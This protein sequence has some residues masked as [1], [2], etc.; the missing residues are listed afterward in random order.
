MSAFWY[1]LVPV[2]GAFISRHN[3]RIFRQRFND[4]CLKPMLDYAAYVL[5]PEEG[6][7]YRFIGGFESTDNRTL[8]IRSEA[9]T[10]P[11]ILEGAQTY[12]LPMAE[13]EERT[14]TLDPRG[15]APEK[16]RWDRVSSLT[17]GA[18][19]FVG[20]K[21]VRQ[22]DR[23]VFAA[24]KDCPLL[25]IFYDGN[26]RSLPIRTIRAG[27]NKNEYWNTI[28]PY[29]FIAGAFSYLI[30]AMYFLSR[31]VFRLTAVTACIALFTPL[32]PILP[33][34][35]VCTLWYQ[36]LWR[37]ARIFR[38][39]R[40]ILHFPLKYKGQLPNG[41][42]YGSA[43]YTVLET[44]IPLLVPDKQENLKKEDWYV[45]GS[46]QESGFPREPSDVFAPFGAAPGN[47]ET[48]ARRYTQKAYVLEILSWL[49]L[50]AGLGLNILFIAAILRITGIW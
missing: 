13:G 44:Q 38:V 9:L 20:G 18:K 45:F 35:V 34:G 47:P 27:R 30:M 2:A 46:L 11:I 16:I 21:V 39:Y 23:P 31:P 22:A 7:I 26:D 14:T 17:E 12:L 33:P 25:I 43:R 10:V 24:A 49:L 6:G 15:E 50:I 1:G 41:E 40:D 3:W 48:L 4:L 19:V 37:Q 42:S 29:S 28:T 8:W 5:L 32:I 36:Q